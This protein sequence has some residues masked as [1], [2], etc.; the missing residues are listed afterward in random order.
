[1][2]VAELDGIEEADEL[3]EVDLLVLLAEEVLNDEGSVAV[4]LENLDEILGADEAFVVGV[5]LLE[6]FMDAPDLSGRD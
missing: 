1:M 6:F 2:F 4:V 3:D 5:E